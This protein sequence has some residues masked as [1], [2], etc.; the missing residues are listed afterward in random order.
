MANIIEARIFYGAHTSS[1]EAQNSSTAGAGRI[2]KA[3]FGVG[4]DVS[5]R[6]L[7]RVMGESGGVA[8]RVRNGECRTMTGAGGHKASYQHVILDNPY[9]LQVDVT[10]DSGEI[11]GSLSFEGDSIS[12]LFYY[13]QG[14]EP[15]RHLGQLYGARVQETCVF[16]GQL[17]G[18][19]PVSG[20]A[21]VEP[22]GLEDLPVFD[23]NPFYVDGGVA[24]AV[25]AYEEAI[26]RLLVADTPEPSSDRTLMAVVGRDPTGS[27]I[28]RGRPVTQGGD[29]LAKREHAGALRTDVISGYDILIPAGATLRRI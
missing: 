15:I 11:A 5:D 18:I 21:K 26:V 1:Y 6:E 2:T 28:Y 4:D 20:T 23:E 29:L 25:P 12:E 7:R 27:L 24:W 9:G 19:K 16:D 17:T 8:D 14:A 3:F 10:L 22:V 13:L